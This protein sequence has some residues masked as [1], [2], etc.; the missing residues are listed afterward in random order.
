MPVRYAR[1]LG[2]D[3]LVQ[4]AYLFHTGTRE[5]LTEGI[6]LVDAGTFITADVVGEG[7]FLGGHILPASSSCWTA[8]PGGEAPPAIQVRPAAA[9]RRLPRT[10]GAAITDSLSR[11]PGL[12]LGDLL[13]R[14]PCGKVVLSGGTPPWSGTW[15]PPRPGAAARSPHR[16]T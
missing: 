6:L 13:R 4:A 12:F 11:L 8:T 14:V 15:S 5:S 1:T 7:G 10:T 16:P 2:E 3:R 9:R